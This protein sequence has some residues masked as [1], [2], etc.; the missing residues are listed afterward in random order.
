MVGFLLPTPAQSGAHSASYAV[1][2]RGLYANR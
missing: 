2:T 1:G